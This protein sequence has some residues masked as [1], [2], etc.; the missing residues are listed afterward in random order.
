MTNPNA[1]TVADVMNTRRLVSVAPD[2][3][4]AF[5]ARLMTWARVRHLPVLR[6]PTLV[7]VFTERD[8]LRYR[9][10]TGGE[11]ALDPV[12]NFMS[13][14]AETVAPEDP[15]ATASALL[16]S[17]GIG[18]LPV[19]S[20][21][22]LVGIVT[23]NDLLAAEVRAAAPGV[24]LEGPVSR[25]MVRHPVVVHPHEPLLEAV[26]LM[27]EH[28]IRHVPVTDDHGRL[29]GMISDRDVR[30]AIGDPNEA[31]H[32][33]LTELEEL[34][35]SGVMTVPADSVT[36]E[37]PLPAAA[38]KLVDAGVGALPVTDRAGR[39]VGI[40]SYVDVV[41]VLLELARARQGG[42]EPRP[43]AGA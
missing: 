39:V 20:D 1:L 43:A 16:L 28:G 30:T 8:Y 5:A 19:M 34:T 4:V 24:T 26:A 12:G 21:D 7:G 2:D 23:A 31:L 15:A 36:D 13:A 10:E 37:L 35:V 33:E 11:G 18:C 14:P 40:V 27:V 3:D 6:G 22:E 9:A 25:I 42:D 17:R 32:R 29:V 41:R 38:D